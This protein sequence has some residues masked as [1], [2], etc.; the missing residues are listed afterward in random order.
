[1]F[2]LTSK[3]ALIFRKKRISSQQIIYLE[4]GVPLSLPI[5]TN[6]ALF[7]VIAIHQ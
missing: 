6:K 2:L 4:L 3:K 7:M 1:M 5:Q